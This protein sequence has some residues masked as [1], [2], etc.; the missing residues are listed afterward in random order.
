VNPTFLVLVFAALVAAPI[1]EEWFYRGLLFRRIYAVGGQLTALV[2]S[3]F[4]FAVIHLNWSGLIIYFW[5]GLVFA[6]TYRICGRLWCAMVV[7]A[8]NN[9]V[10]LALLFWAP[11]AP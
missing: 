7:H 11:P 2:V 10:A 9:A 3:A 6:A 4:A 5:L 1:A 8:G